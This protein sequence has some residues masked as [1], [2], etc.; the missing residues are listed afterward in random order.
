MR[1]KLEQL[2][3]ELN[4]VEQLLRVVDP[5]SSYT[6]EK[7]ET[8]EDHKESFVEPTEKEVTQE[9]SEKAQ[10][11]QRVLR[12]GVWLELHSLEEKKKLEQIK[13]EN[14]QVSVSSMAPPTKTKRVLGPTMPSPEE[15]EA[16]RNSQISTAENS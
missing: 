2:F 3:Q 12:N 8:A 16:M 1:S 4:E 13:S 7:K 9:I 5:T 14:S 11:I 10:G 15:L 6:K